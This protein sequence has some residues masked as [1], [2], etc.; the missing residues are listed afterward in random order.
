[1][2]D[3]IA[4]TTTTT[5]VTEVIEQAQQVVDSTEPIADTNGTNSNEVNGVT[6]AEK[7]NGSTTAVANG[8]A[9]PSKTKKEKVVEPPEPPKDPK[10]DP[11][12]WLKQQTRPALH[13]INFHLL[14]WI[15]KL[16]YA[17][18]EESKRPALPGSKKDAITKSQFLAS[19]RDGTLLAGLA[20]KL[21][22]GTVETVHSV[23]EAAKEKANAT[24]NIQSF[25]TFVKEKVGLPEEHIFSVED[26]QEKGKEGYQAVCNTLFQLAQQAQDKFNAASLDVE[27][28]AEDAKNAV[29]TNVVVEMVKTV[30]NKVFKR[31]NSTAPVAQQ[32]VNGGSEEVNG[33]DKA[34]ATAE[35]INNKET[36]EVKAAN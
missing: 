34:E 10:E 9:T 35:E 17:E 1:M 4:S 28:V 31:S 27:K 2:T 29:H 11:L 15:N 7:T 12:G 25:I 30:V 22:P 33:A 3:V 32:T 13:K 16:V 23:E 26:L 14:E 6:P 18:E 21:S 19:L 36:T 24:S 8:S 20:N 5:T